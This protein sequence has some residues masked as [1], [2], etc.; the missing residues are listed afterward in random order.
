MTQSSHSPI[1]ILTLMQDSRFRKQEFPI[2]ASKVFLAHAAMSPFPRRVADAITTY[3]QKVST[4]GQWE[5]IYSQ[6]ETETRKYAANLLGANV[7]EIAF[8]SST[9]IGLSTI[10]SGI[11]WKDGDNIIIADGDFPS[12]IYPWLNLQR[13]GIQAKFIPR[14]KDGI[15]N[16]KDVVELIDEKTRLVSLSTVNY[17]TGFKIDVSTI[18]KYLHQKGILFCLDAIQSVGCFPLDTT[19]VDFLAC[20]ANKWLL[21]PVGIGILYVKR[22]NLDLL[23]PVLSGWKCVQNNKNYTSYNLCLL[24]SAKRFEPGYSSIMGLVGLHAAL[25]L[26]LEVKVENIA[27]RLINL[28]KIMVTSLRAMGYTVF[29]NDEFGCSSGITTFSS[30]KQDITK[31]HETLDESGF[32]VSSRVGLDGSK[33][34]RI[35]PH[36][37]NTEE[38][39]IRFLDHVQ[40]LK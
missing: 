13:F 26:L 36:F 28:R 29:G 23:N 31:L 18:G 5:Y 14:N 15:I 8:V 19:Y 35:A 25:G 10:A 24:E 21:G 7:D 6:I 4:E 40:R 11:P 39:I 20:G 9:S 33:C 3:V 1:N 34:I 30:P 17:I 27:D 38:E 2:T 37:Y 16:L 12:N 32:V 22:K